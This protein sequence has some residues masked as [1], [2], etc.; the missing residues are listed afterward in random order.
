MKPVL[1]ALLLIITLLST[2]V[3]ASGRN[4]TL[5]DNYFAEKKYTQALAEYISLTKIGNPKAYYQL[6]VIH[7]N[8]FWVKKNFL[9]SIIWFSLAAEY[10]Y[11]DAGDIVKKLIAQVSAEQQPKVNKLIEVYIAKFGKSSV[12]KKYYPIINDKSIGFKINIVDNT[13]KYV[14]SD[15]THLNSDPEPEDEDTFN[16][17][18]GSDDFDSFSDSSIDTA[19][20]TESLDDLLNT[21]YFI[22]VDYDIAKD[23]SRRNLTPIESFGLIDKVLY[24]LKSTSITTPTFKDEPI[25]FLDRTYKGLADYTKAEFK[26]KQST[27]YYRIRKK[28]IRFQNND[29]LTS[30][31]KYK[32]ASLLMNITWLPS[33]DEQINQLLKESA[34]DGVV[35]AQLEYGLKLYREQEDIKSALYWISK[36]AQQTNR[37]AEFTLGK[38]LLDSPW[39][40][41]D[42]NKALIWL[43]SAAKK[44]HI[45]SIKKV[46]ELKLLA[47][48]KT[49]H[50]T[51]EANEYLDNMS[52]TQNM[53][54]IY[55]YLRAIAYT[56]DESRQLGT[57]FQHMRKAISLASDLNWDITEWNDWLERWGQGRVTVQDL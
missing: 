13:D 2:G 33:T 42:E 38:I 19:R 46:I 43:E 28:Q 47:K 27:L 12:N 49:L 39:V 3:N 34:Q 21:P 11:K 29:K 57:A 23:G 51:K 36:A 56:Q 35:L 30:V 55:H 50:N 10:D 14:T 44:Q 18:I 6:G 1:K 26:N 17:S 7:H 31:E 9:E 37:R 22:V 15:V 45:P 48:D 24:S 20:S 53:D 54:P 32:Y 4:L 52:E 5:A 25:S 40:I 41:R 8:G 16:S